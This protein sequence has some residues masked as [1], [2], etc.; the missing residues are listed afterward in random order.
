MVLLDTSVWRGFFAG[1]RRFSAV[2]ELLDADE[3][4]THPWVAGELV[5]GGLSTREEALFLR[6]RRVEVV[7]DE[8]LLRFIRAHTLA[9][10]GIGWVDAQL[11]AAAKLAG[12]RLWTVDAALLAASRS[13]RVHFTR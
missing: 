1:D 2:S 11:L 13:L 9:R 5:L 8:E 4:L 10:R 3:V 7:R 12:A 6:L